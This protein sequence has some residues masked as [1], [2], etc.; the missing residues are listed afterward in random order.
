M[1]EDHFSPA[2]KDEIRRSGQISPVQTKPIAKRMD[3]TPND[4]L[5]L[6]VLAFDQRHLAAA[7]GIYLFQVTA[8]CQG[9]A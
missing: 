2:R 9:V 8:P 6:G 5:R 3:E 4:N 7:S 1:D